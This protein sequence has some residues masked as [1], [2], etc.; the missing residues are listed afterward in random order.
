[1]FIAVGEYNKK[2]RSNTGRLLVFDTSDC[3]VEYIEQHEIEENNIKV[4]NVYND[5]GFLKPNMLSLHHYLWSK[6]RIVDFVC[7][8]SSSV[9]KVGDM[10]I[11]IQ[12]KSSNSSKGMHRVTSVNDIKC[13]L[14][15]ELSMIYM[16]LFEDYIILRMRSRFNINGWYTVAVGKNSVEQWNPDLSCCTNKQLAVRVDMLSRV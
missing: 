14:N 7:A 3:T 1:M 6:N 2:P 5:K 15:C 11:T 13:L 8:L 16:F 12:A 4:E 9:I 10:K